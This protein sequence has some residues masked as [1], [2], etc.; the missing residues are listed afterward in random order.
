VTVTVC[1]FVLQY[2]D[3]GDLLFVAI[4]CGMV[5]IFTVCGSVL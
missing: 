4:C 5:V 3:G 2:G 1:G